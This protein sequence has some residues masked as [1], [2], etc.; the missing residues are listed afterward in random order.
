[1]TSATQSNSGA[2]AYL[3]MLAAGIGKP[4][5]IEAGD[6]DKREVLATVRGLL[7]GVERSSGST[8]WLADLYQKANGPARNTTRCG[9]T[10]PHQGNQRQADA[11]RKEPL[12]AI[13]PA[14]ACRSAIR[15]SASSTAGAA[16]R[17]SFSTICRLSCQDEPRRDRR[18]RPARRAGPRGSAQGRRDHQSRPQ[19]PAHGG[20]PAGAGRHSE[21]A[22]ALSGSAAAAVTDRALSR[23]LRQHAGHGESSCSKRCGSC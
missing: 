19:P 6:L 13:Y 21:G 16:R 18:H 23:R 10:R 8:G 12:Y 11:D 1:M 7:R 5:L 15:R 14:T 2:A 20:A 4:D 9:T 22:G 17:S 3:A